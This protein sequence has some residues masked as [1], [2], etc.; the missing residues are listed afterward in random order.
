MRFT[1]PGAVLGE[2]VQMRIRVVVIMVVAVI[3][4]SAAAVSAQTGTL[5][6]HITDADTGDDLIG[7]D[8]VLVG[9]GKAVQTDLDGRFAFTDLV[10]GT[11]NLKIAYLG[12]APQDVK[13]IQVNPGRPTT[14]AIRLEAAEAFTT[15]DLVITA[16]RILTTESAVLAE[17]KEAI[18]IGD[19]ISAAQ[20]SQSPDGTSSDALKRVIGLSIVDDKYVFVRGVTDRYNGTELNG[21][22]VTSTDTDTDRKSFSFDMIPANLLAN[23]V[24]VKTAT[25]DLPGDFSGGLVQVSTLEFP[26]QRSLRWNWSVGM[27]DLT[28]T[29][30]F[31][32]STGGGRDWLGEDDGTRA[33]PGGLAN[34]DLARALPNTWEPRRGR[35]PFDKSLGFSY[36]DRWQWGD[37][38]L[39]LI[40]A[41]SYKT[42]F[43]TEE[44]TDH[45]YSQ[46]VVDM[47]DPIED[48]VLEDSPWNMKGRRY[49]SS[50]L[51]GGLANLNLRLSPRH[52]LSLKTNASRSAKE[53][54][55]F[56]AGDDESAGPTTRQT[57]VWNQR[58]LW[59]AQF[60]G[61]HSFTDVEQ[62]PGFDW[63]WHRSS[64]TAAEPDRKHLE[65]SLT[66]DESYTQKENYR[67]WSSLTEDSD[68]GALNAH[69][70]LLGGEFKAGAGL[71][72]RERD[73]GI[74]A[75][76]AD[77]SAISA[78]NAGIT[79]WG[80]GS[81]FI[82]ENFGPD[83][84]RFVPLTVFT[85]TYHGTQEL[86]TWYAM[87]DRPL[88]TGP[89]DL[90]LTGGVRWE[91]S[92]QK[93]S[94]LP[95][96]GV[97]EPVVSR[98]DKRDALPSGNLTWRANDRLNLR[99]GYYASV[100]RPEF[101]EMSDVLYL[102]FST[103][104]NVKG[105]PRLK[106]ATVDNYDVRLEFFPQQGEVVA[107]SWFRKT[108]TDAIE[109]SLYSSPE[110]FVRTWVNSP[111]GTNEGYEL[112]YH[113]SLGCFWE[114]LAPFDLLVNYTHV[115]SAIKYD[116]VYTDEL[117]NIVRIPRE[118]I[119]Q[120]QSPW[121]LNLSLAWKQ[122]DWGTGAS[123]LL[124]RIARRLDAVGD[125][126]DEDA[127]EES[128]TQLDAA[129]SQSLGAGWKL[130]ATAKN[131]LD[132]NEAI[133][134]GHEGR[135]YQTITRGV[136]YALSF[137]L[138]L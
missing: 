134:L 56:M 76:A 1:P 70:P 96:L 117:G 79:Q 17:R 27:N 54:V 114:A 138:D 58:K 111:Q 102:D 60:G 8:V 61:E 34:N 112:E 118:R 45:P 23:T 122:P 98:I 25:P 83:R 11:Y 113:R 78:A 39:G 35:A 2:G 62:A 4:C 115:T 9:S 67:T 126:R 77:P 94:T 30:D 13:L 31:W 37:R 57:I 97:T 93:V 53:K 124:N 84:F 107:A 89:L 73:Y 92:D 80:A 5:D 43:S 99:L 135:P 24:V 12:Y 127:Y 87:F 15:D 69:L 85:G 66:A 28:T 63:N 46:L 29:H 86:R 32:S 109:D 133:T 33:L 136:N 106:R 48:I 6:G 74:D 65:Y 47:P 131:L 42:G 51:I 128:R 68:G 38:E 50:L 82:P 100:N 59:L 71:E 40:S 137:S 36:G 16:D 7:V 75:W 41:L 125:S 121:S 14:V 20:I 52:K 64:S 22:A 120:G 3:F 49:E 10:A 19:A 18:V 101:R 105:N 72:S 110:R 123:L 108:F 104:Q 130:K 132:E 44:Y 81:I 88:Q 90:R 21:V 26:D 103:F 129:L 55:Q 91:D 95:E 119:M 116:E